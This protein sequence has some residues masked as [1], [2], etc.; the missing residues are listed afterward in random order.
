MGISVLCAVTIYLLRIF[1]TPLETALI[2]D[3]RSRVYKRDIIRGILREQSLVWEV[4][5][6]G[7]RELLILGAR[8]E[9][10]TCDFI[11]NSHS[12]SLLLSYYS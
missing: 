8:G 11:G 3:W 2:S 7:N 4:L 10:R 12:T 6:N 5:S 9:P 1:L